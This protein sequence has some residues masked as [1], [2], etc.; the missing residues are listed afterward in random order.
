MLKSRWQQG[1]R[2][3]ALDRR[4]RPQL[5]FFCQFHNLTAGF[6]TDRSPIMLSGVKIDV[7]KDA[8]FRRAFAERKMA[9]NALLRDDDHFAR[10]NLPFILSADD[11]KPQ[12]SELSTQASPT[13]P[14]T[15]GRMPIGSRT[16]MSL[17]LVM[18][19]MEK[20]PST[21]RGRLPYVRNIALQR[22]P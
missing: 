6:M 4:D 9:L 12:V 7:F 10:C 19:T 16:P 21:L 18:A 14:S 3:R 17:L 20:A 15:R 22:A 13:R 8:E 1:Y 11:V 5:G 2:C